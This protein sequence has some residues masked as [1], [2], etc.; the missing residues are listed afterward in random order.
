MQVPAIAD[1]IIESKGIKVT[2]LVGSWLFGWWFGCIELVDGLRGAVLFNY[3][4]RRKYSIW[5]YEYDI[6]ND[7]YLTCLAYMSFQEI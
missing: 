7:K 4:H 5:L 6:T 2:I 1:A 3:L